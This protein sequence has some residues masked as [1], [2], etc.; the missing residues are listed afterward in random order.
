M[1]TFCNAIS[2]KFERV[3]EVHLVDIPCTNIFFHLCFLRL[4]SGELKYG[5]IIGGSMSPSFDHFVYKVVNV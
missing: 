4:C 3:D 5:L 2:L 1:L